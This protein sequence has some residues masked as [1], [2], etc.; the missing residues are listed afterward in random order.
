[1]QSHFEYFNSITIE[2]LIDYFNQS[3]EESNQMEFK[4]GE[5]DISKLYKEICAFA[6]T[7]GGVLIWGAPKEININSGEK[8]NANKVCQG[9]LTPT[10]I[11]KTEDSLIQTLMANISPAPI[12]IVVRKFSYEPGYAYIIII[13]KS[14][15]PP[16]QVNGTYYIRVNT[17]SMPAPHGIVQAF[18]NQKKPI[19][20]VAKIKI[21]KELLEHNKE[22]GITIAVTNNSKY[23]AVDIEGFVSIVGKL[24]EFKE[25]PELNMVNLKEGRVSLSTGLKF[26]SAS[27]LGLWVW[28]NIYGVKILDEYC[29]IELF[30]WARET[31]GFTKLFKLYSNGT[32]VEVNLNGTDDLE[33]EYKEWM[34]LDEEA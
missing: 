19:D 5:T 28:Y 30:I 13:P 24:Y 14:L 7:D 34:A 15:Y 31:H 23:P 12:G 8:N 27:I 17:M 21:E 4:S 18:F 20:L 3:Q 25:K 16:H 10:E 22:V 32:I 29:Y 2:A 33:K 6:N 11:N 9:K 1:M 26:K